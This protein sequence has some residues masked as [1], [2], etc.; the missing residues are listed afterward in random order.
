LN[1]TKKKLEK[2]IKTAEFVAIKDGLIVREVQARGEEIAAREVDAAELGEIPQGLKAGLPTFHIP[3]IDFSNRTFKLE[4]LKAL[5]DK[6][7]LYMLL[8]N[9]F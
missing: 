6:H 1:F 9:T 2:E 7:T 8:G 4:V 5:K 3:A